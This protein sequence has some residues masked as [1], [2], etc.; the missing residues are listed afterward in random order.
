MWTEVARFDFRGAI[1]AAATNCTQS[2]LSLPQVAVSS[3]SKTLEETATNCQKNFQTLGSA[4]QE[5]SEKLH[6]NV[7]QL[8]DILQQSFPFENMQQK[9]SGD[10][11]KSQ[12]SENLLS[13][14]GGLPGEMPAYRKR[15]ERQMS[16]HDARKEA[17]QIDDLLFKGSSNSKVAINFLFFDS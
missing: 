16:D 10:I 5:N 15:L 1:G 3:T 7:A 6:Q 14:Y 13:K 8:G 11:K 4:L 17:G 2:I 9:I 12:S